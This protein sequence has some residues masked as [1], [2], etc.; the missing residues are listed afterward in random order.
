[1][2]ILDLIQL[3]K[4]LPPRAREASK[5]D[6]GH[7]LITGGDYGMAGA[8]RM[9][10]EAAARVGAGLTSI[11]TRPEHISAIVSA[12]PELMCHPIQQAQDLKKLLARATVVVLGPGLGQSSWSQELFHYVIA[13]A[14]QPKV[15]DADGLNLLAK[16]PQKREDWILTPHPGEA[17]RLLNSTA[18][19]IQK[20]R[21]TAVQQLQ[22]KF[23]G[24][25]VLKGA[26]TL[27]AGSES[28]SICKSG[29]PG[30][31]SGGMGDV[32][33]GVMGGLLAQHLNLLQAAE[34]GVSLHATAADLAAKE[35]GERGLL[36]LD[37]MEYLRKLVN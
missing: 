10:G 14:S 15:I 31:A 6:F 30:M 12:R 32:L 8:V 20:N 33:S 1:M 17:A 2:K 21:N 24:I 19:A 26:G 27:I 5:S 9:A 16:Q 18:E 3:Q 25:V 29:N 11:A 13:N 23:G 35:K 36:A 22:N 37:L 28:L 7:V 4:I 34:L